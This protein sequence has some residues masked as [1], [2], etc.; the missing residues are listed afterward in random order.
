MSEWCAEV[1]HK[2]RQQNKGMDA[3]SRWATLLLTLVNEVTS[4][5]CLIELCTK[6]EDFAHI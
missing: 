3:L 5:E 4:F 2:S 1:H 6:D